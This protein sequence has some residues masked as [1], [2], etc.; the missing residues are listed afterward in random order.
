VPS[1]RQ[2]EK[3][4]YLIKFLTPA[5]IQSA[6]VVEMPTKLGRVY[7]DKQ[8]R[9]HWPPVIL[10]DKVVSGCKIPAS[11]IARFQSGR[12]VPRDKSIRKLALLYDKYM[13]N[14]L[15]AVGA[16]KENAR[17]LCKME[18]AVVRKQLFRYSAWARAIQANH[19]KRGREVDLVSLQW[20]MAHSTH[21]IN[22]WDEIAKTSGLQIY[23]KKKSPSPKRASKYEH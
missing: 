1:L 19:A 20:S 23:G 15:R 2:T 7:T 14:Q 3:A 4:N 10:R 11:T 9:T 17:S 21:G 5:E 13:Y 22:E 12:A 18:P 6:I 16:N 8:G